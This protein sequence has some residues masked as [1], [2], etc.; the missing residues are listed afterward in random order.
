VFVHDGGTELSSACAAKPDGYIGHDYVF[1]GL[2]EPDTVDFQYEP[3]VPVDCLYSE[4]FFIEYTGKD[5]FFEFKTSESLQDAIYVGNCTYDD[6]IDVNGDPKVSIVDDYFIG[7]DGNRIV[8]KVENGEDFAFKWANFG[9][10]SSGVKATQ[11]FVQTEFEIL[12]N[13]YTY[14]VLGYANDDV[15]PSTDSTGAPVTSSFTCI[16]GAVVANEEVVTDSDVTDGIVICCCVD[17]PPTEDPRNTVCVKVLTSSA[18]CEDRCNILSDFSY[19]DPS[20]HTCTTGGYTLSQCFEEHAYQGET[21]PFL[22]NNGEPSVPIELTE[23]HVPG[24]TSHMVTPSVFFDFQ[25]LPGEDLV[26]YRI[27]VISNEGEN[28]TFDFGC[29]SGAIAVSLLP[30]CSLDAVPIACGRTQEFAIQPSNNASEPNVDFVIAP[31][32]LEPGVVY[33]LRMRTIDGTDVGCFTPCVSAV[34]MPPEPENAHC[35]TPLFMARE[36][37]QQRRN[38]CHPESGFNLDECS[39]DCFCPSAQDTEVC[40]DTSS[41][42]DDDC[43]FINERVEGVFRTSDYPLNR[44]MYFGS[45]FD[46]VNE[47]IIDDTIP[48]RCFIFNGSFVSSITD[49]PVVPNTGMTIVKKAGLFDTSQAEF[50]LNTIGENTQIITSGGS[51]L[52]NFIQ[53]GQELSRIELC[54]TDFAFSGFVDSTTV[55]CISA[56]GGSV[57]NTE[58]PDVDPLPIQPISQLI[59]DDTDFVLSYPNE[60]AT[61]YCNQPTPEPTSSPTLS[62]PAPPPPPTPRPTSIAPRLDE[63][64]YNGLC[65]DGIDNDGDGQIDCEDIG[66]ISDWTCGEGNCKDGKDNDGNG[67]IDC[68]DFSCCFEPSC[69]DS[70]LRVCREITINL[71]YCGDGLDNDNDGAQ[72]CSDVGCCFYEGCINSE[73]RTCPESSFCQDGIDNDKNGFIDCQDFACRFDEACTPSGVNQIQVTTTTHHP[74]GHTHGNESPTA[75]TTMSAT[76]TTTTYAS[77]D[78]T[79]TTTHHRDGH[80][81]GNDSP[82]TTTT[83]TT[84][85]TTTTT[86]PTTTTTTT[87][88][89]TTTTQSTGEIVQPNCPSVGTC[90]SSDGDAFSVCASVEDGCPA[91]SKR[92][93]TPEE[94]DSCSPEDPLQE[95]CMCC[96]RDCGDNWTQSTCAQDNSGYKTCTAAGTCVDRFSGVVDTELTCGDGSDCECCNFDPFAPSSST[97]DNTRTLSSRQA[98]FTTC[99]SE[100]KPCDGEFLNG[101]TCES[102]GFAG[103]Q[104]ACHPQCYTYDATNCIPYGACCTGVEESNMCIEKSTLSA[105]DQESGVFVANAVTCTPNLCKSVLQ[106]TERIPQEAQQTGVIEFGTR[107]TS[108]RQRLKFNGTCSF[109]CYIGTVGG[110]LRS[111]SNGTL[112][113]ISNAHVWSSPSGYSNE[114]NCARSIPPRRGTSSTSSTTNQESVAD[115]AYQSGTCDL[116]MSNP[117]GEVAA[118]S[119]LQPNSIQKVDVSMVKLDSQS[120]Y[121]QAVQMGLGPQTKGEPAVPELGMIVVKSSRTSGFTI[122]QIS[123]VSV[124]LYVAHNAGDGSESHYTVLMEDQ[125]WIE[126]ISPSF[127]FMRGGDS[128]SV[129]FEYETMKAVA[130]GHA[131]SNIGEGVACSIQSVLDEFFPGGDGEVAGQDVASVLKKRGHNGTS[132]VDVH[133]RDAF[134]PLSANIREMPP[135]SSVTQAKSA[136]SMLHAVLEP[137]MKD[138]IVIGHYVSLRRE[139][140]NEPCIMILANKNKVSERNIESIIPSTIL[141]FPV[142]VRYTDPIKAN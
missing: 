42:N 112:Y 123:G 74:D 8:C 64:F 96:T 19:V 21:A 105:C 51:V 81:H 36:T 38:P 13:A 22:Q 98:V 29:N 103:G 102:L 4:P 31:G 16:D 129:I 130:L 97:V 54:G 40:S 33:R 63:T 60:A 14:Q 132:T 3:T 37:P 68:A 73:L 122:G 7:E 131:G 134:I 142:F 106:N 115:V 1:D 85:T 133:P 55:N 34:I 87:T 91:G 77:T 104:L 39:E 99:S 56:V 140:V 139:H 48:D 125:L 110:V 128:G 88:T 61:V 92:D 57:D 59:S 76:H 67:F 35:D 111:K 124:T 65:R 90:T 136:Q 12:F 109:S 66:C 116:S 5:C 82:T 121:E 45:A 70:P 53:D 23:Y 101:E 78:T 79:T 95:T 89:A 52:F 108:T 93:E 72:D 62:P 49:L 119:S 107:T 86:T 80:T 2:A 41:C 83:T 135:A 69:L 15:V 6:M 17:N 84:P 118:F 100:N 127:S 120:L 20:H 75:T 94:G 137:L 26:E 126:G 138:N 10:S 117:L 44:C 11:K 58:L 27:S 24:A 9:S 141:G 114:D 46:L 30:S 71:D 28:C 25:A 32:V 18:S 47:F 113:A 43:L 50:S